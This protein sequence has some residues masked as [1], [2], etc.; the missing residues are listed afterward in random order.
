M[1]KILATLFILTVLSFSADFASAGC[2]SVSPKDTWARIDNQTVVIYRGEVA[3][4]IIK[5]QYCIIQATS[6][7]NI[8]KDQVCSN[9]TISIDR[10]KCTIIK[11]YQ[12]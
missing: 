11:A 8:D 7:L 3:T 6:D 1:R 10:Q 4:G 9:D 12:L 2:I 5:V